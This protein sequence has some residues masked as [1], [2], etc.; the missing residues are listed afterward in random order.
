M[1]HSERIEKLEEA[2]EQIHGAIRNI[3]EALKGSSSSRQ[4]ESYIISHLRNWADGENPFDATSIPK[5]IK[6]IEENPICDS[7]G[8]VE[9]EGTGL[10]CESCEAEGS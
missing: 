2:Q 10:I 7:C 9:V 3:K 4:A 6:Q 8:D 5:L 1:E